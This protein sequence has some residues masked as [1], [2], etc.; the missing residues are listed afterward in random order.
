[1][2]KD[3][4]FAISVKLPRIYLVKFDC[5]IGQLK[6]VLKEN[7]SILRYTSILLLVVITIALKIPRFPHQQGYDGF[8]LT[9]EANSLLN[10]TANQWL[11]H[12][13]SLF[14]IFSFSG[15]PIGSVSVLAFFIVISNGSLDLA[16]FYY[17]SFF[18]VITIGTTYGLLDYLTEDHWAA[19]AGTTFYLFFP[20][21]YS[22]TY[23]NVNTRAPLLA[24]LPLFIWALLRWNSERKYGYLAYSLNVWFVMLFFHR[25]AILLLAPIVIGALYPFIIRFLK[26]QAKG[27]TNRLNIITWSFIIGFLE[28]TLWL[29]VASIILFGFQ[30]KN[31]IPMDIFLNENLLIIRD[32]ISFALDYFLFFGPGLIIAA[33]GFLQYSRDLFHE[34]GLFSKERSSYTFLITI[35]T[36]FAIM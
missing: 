5:L 13:L 9:I 33:F 31:P 29:I 21:V 18:S 36:P 25:V 19:L 32:L 26:Q 12:P 20:I 6:R 7:P 28:I 14:G 17:V 27:K 4:N 23:N 2:L 16:C 8:V 3:C 35:A 1:M 30:L 22:F 15:Y 24:L 10:G 34:D 11:I